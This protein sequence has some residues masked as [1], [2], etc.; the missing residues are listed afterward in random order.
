VVRDCWLAGD[1]KS[2]L[3]K[4]PNIIA[5]WSSLINAY[6]TIKRNEPP[7]ARRRWP[8]WRHGALR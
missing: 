5:I 2:Q 4:K 6:Q 3:V 8:S 1:S 7:G